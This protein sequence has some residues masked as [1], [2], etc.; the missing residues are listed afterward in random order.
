MANIAENV[1]GLDGMFGKIGPGMCKLSMDGKIAVKTSNGYK[2]YDVN[3][4]RLTNCDNLVFN[5]GEQFFFLIPTSK[6][7]PGDIILIDGKPNCVISSDKHEIK[8]INYETSTINT[9]AKE[10]HMFMGNVYFYGKIVSLF[11]NDFIKGKNGMNKMMSYVLMSEMLKGGTNG[12]NT[13][14][15]M[16]PMMMLAGNG[17]GMMN[18][19]ENLFDNEDTDEDEVENENTAEE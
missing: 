8:V 2:T 14:N 11:G 9:V 13:I 16:L 19:F 3:T 5:V 1:L 6:V 18:M 15:S 10:R 17:N 7:S 12:N 4:H